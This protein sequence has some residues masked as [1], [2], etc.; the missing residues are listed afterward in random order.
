MI[1]KAPETNNCC[2][3][4]RKEWEI[5]TP[6]H[7]HTG[8]QPC[9]HSSRDWGDMIHLQTKEHHDCQEP[10][11]VGNRPGRSLPR[12]FRGSRTPGFQ[13]SGLQNCEYRNF[14]WL[15]QMGPG[16]TVCDHLLWEPYETN[17]CGYQK[18]LSYIC[19]SRCISIGLCC[20]RVEKEPSPKTQVFS[21]EP[22]SLGTA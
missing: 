10:P 17:T 18:M 14:L 22:N 6:S 4:K 19:G 21:M 16:K 2:F 3:Y 15:N 11:D 8:R 5:W 9:K 1:I 7:R 12:A 13:T 20:A